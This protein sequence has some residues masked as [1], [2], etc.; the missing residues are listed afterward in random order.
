MDER[1]TKANELL[2]KEEFLAELKQATNDEE[3]QKLFGKYG[4]EL[5]LE[6]VA[7]MCEAACMENG[8]GADE[9]SADALDN[10]SGG[11]MVTACFLLAGASLGFYTAYGYRTIKSWKKK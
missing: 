9:L 4:V 1:F 3:V 2:V 6:D 8:E 10:V 5:S 7:T 11:V